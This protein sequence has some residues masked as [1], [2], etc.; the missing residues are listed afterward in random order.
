M[1]KY[2]ITPHASG[3]SMHYYVHKALGPWPF[4]NWSWAAVYSASS[5]EDCE[6]WIRDTL[7]TESPAGQALALQKEAEA[8]ER[9]AQRTA[10]INQMKADGWD[11]DLARMQFINE[12]GEVRSL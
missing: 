11:Y 5:R 12:D 6:K 1:P 2:K 3:S 9:A 10:L 4:R 8:R 7:F